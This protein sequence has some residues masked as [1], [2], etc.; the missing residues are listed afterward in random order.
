M[1]QLSLP[2]YWADRQRH[3]GSH[4]MSGEGGV[5]YIELKSVSEDEL[6]SFRNDVLEEAALKLEEIAAAFCFAD[7]VRLLKR[8]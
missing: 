8:N 3:A 4:K 2:C 5:E 7:Y 1:R 6:K